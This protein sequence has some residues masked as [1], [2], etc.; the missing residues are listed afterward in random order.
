MFAV[1]AT[2]W[3]LFL[4]IGM[5]M[6]GNGLP[7][8]L[9]G[10]RATGEG[11]PTAVTGLVMSCYYLGF[12]AGSVLAPRVISTVGHIRVFSALA[13]LASAAAVVHAVFVDPVTWGAMR[14]VTGFCY[15]G[16]YVVAESWLND[17]ATNETRGQLLSVYMVV[18]L[19][20]AVGGQAL[21]NLADPNGFILF[22]LASV[23]VS[24]ALVPISLTA[25]P[26]PDFAAP[27]KV[28]LI[29]LYRVSPLGVVGAI[30]T[31]CAHGTLFGMGAVY[32][33][34]IGLSVAEISL[35]MGLTYTG[36][37]LLQWPI[38]RLSDRFDR[39]RM[40]SIV[41]F[42]AAIFA[43]AAIPLALIAEAL[44]F[45]TLFL[46]GGM[47]LPLY[48]LCIA[49]TNDHL[50]PKQMVAASGTLVL[51]GGIGA[52]FGPTLAA[53]LMALIG[54]DG[55]LFALGGVHAALGGFAIYRMSRRAATPLEEQH[56]TVPVVSG[57]V[58][59]TA[60]LSVEALRDQMDR[61]LAQMSRSQMNRW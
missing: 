6:L 56:A 29:Q 51:L 8:S 21:L 5:M 30:A 57:A 41:T 4:G 3:A 12:L 26:A 33:D 35:F 7:A 11:F 34:R 58:T 14:F 61:D 45:A 53:G 2:S 27:A 23:L 43:L 32:G 17:R 28:G 47:T 16:L 36:G 9:L 20:G 18:V 25:A 31:G 13:S 42:L 59:P 49:H 50:E 22:V 15:A 10:I 55:F 24:L 46:F 38:G 52:S 1:V 48:S 37:L 60:A 19:G 54:A 39:R 40:I 44:M